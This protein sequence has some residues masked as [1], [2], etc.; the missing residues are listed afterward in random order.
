MMAFNIIKS[1][2]FDL[3]Y[4]TAL[5]NSK[6]I[7]FWLRFKGKMQGNNYQIDKE[8]LVNIPIIEPKNIE[9]FILLF[10]IV[11]YLYSDKS[12]INTSVT[13]EIIAKHFEEV[14]DGCVFELYFKEHM[15]SNDIVIRELVQK[16]MSNIFDVNN[17]DVI[18]EESFWEL[19]DSMPSVQYRL[20][21]MDR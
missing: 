6:L 4:L 2:R 8:P 15:Q 5:L 17:F 9:V 3:K 13:N 1:D 21:E 19:V 10:E 11:H 20:R 18:D 14:I 7:A 12:K 16:E